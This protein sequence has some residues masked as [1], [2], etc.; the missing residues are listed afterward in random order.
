[1]FKRTIF[2]GLFAAMLVL[3]GFAVE[4]P[5]PLNAA[6]GQR[7][8]TAAAGDSPVMCD[9]ETLTTDSGNVI[10]TARW[11]P[12][13]SGPITLDTGVSGETLPN[14]YTTYETLVSS[15]AG[16]NLVLERLADLP[17]RE[18]YNFQGFYAGENGAGD[19]VVDENGYFTADATT[20]V[21]ETG[22]TATWY[23][24]WDPITYSCESGT[25]WNGSYPC[26]PC[27]KNSYCPGDNNIAYG[28]VEA[29]RFDCP[30]EYPNSNAGATQKTDCFGTTVSCDPGKYMK[31]GET[32]CNTECPSNS[33][34]PGGIYN[35]SQTT[36]QGIESCGDLKSPEGSQRQTD[37]GHILNIEGTQLYLHAA[38][39]NAHT[40]SPSF[41]VKIGNEKWY[42]DMTKITN[43][44]KKPISNDTTK[45]WHVEYNGEDYAVHNRY[46][47]CVH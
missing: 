43:E 30:A 22:G 25:Y 10:I 36:D 9:S 47:D 28:K 5:Y 12:N 33:Y 17:V 13:K 6:N 31:K 15:D 2:V 37:C 26:L 45:V 11:N 20:Q 34:C 42:A 23:A 19:Q 41:V 4:Y 3:P 21:T 44:C 46:T 38:D 8:G 24:S 16:G 14:V 1:M 29:G 18:G 32:T 40:T 27:P 7:A 39:D 35:M